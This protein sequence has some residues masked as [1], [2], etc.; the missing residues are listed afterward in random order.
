[1]V[2]FCLIDTAEEDVVSIASIGSLGLRRVFQ[3]EMIWR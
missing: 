1:M 2:F 3:A